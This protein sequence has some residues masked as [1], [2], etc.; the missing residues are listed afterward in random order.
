MRSDLKM[1][2]QAEATGQGCVPVEDAEAK[3]EG[4]DGN[5]LISSGRSR[6]E[7]LRVSGL[8]VGM[9]GMPYCSAGMAESIETAPSQA[10]DRPTP[11]AVLARLIE[12]NRRF[13]RGEL[14]HP[15]R[16]PEDFAPLAEGQAPQAIIVGCA[17]SRVPPEVVFDQGVG[18]LFVVRVAGNVV[19][20]SGPFVKGSIE[21]A[22]AE[23]GARLIVVL[24]HTACGAVKAAVAHI[25]AND[26]LPGAIRDLV[27]VIRPAAAAVR[28]KPGEKLEN[29]TRMNVALGVERL[30]GL[31]PILS[32]LVK[33]G[34]LKVVGAVYD[35]RTGMV[36]F[37]D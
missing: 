23:L 26:T 22:V 28:G 37:L 17:D 11:D 32:P 3:K 25:D 24:G 19:A 18:D 9:F 4:L 27:E 5:D 34:E 2:I 10:G 15:G 35:L 31:D 13:V 14:T 36:N 33:S 20:G 6:R 12:G 29:A 30:K 7:F 8:A 1:G 16:R 21:F